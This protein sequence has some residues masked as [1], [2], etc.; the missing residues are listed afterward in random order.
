MARDRIGGKA[1]KYPQDAKKAH[2]EGTVVLEATI[3]VSGKVED[4][5]V[6]QGPAMLQQATVD[7]VKKWKYKPIVRNGRPVKVRT[8]INVVFNL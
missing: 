7:A 6:V 3:S 8:Q 4:L 5:C 1:P 2:I